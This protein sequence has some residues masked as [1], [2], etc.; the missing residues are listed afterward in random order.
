[1]NK[2]TISLVKCARCAHEWWPR[3]PEPPKRCAHCKALNWQRP[4]HVKREPVV[5]TRPPGAV[6]KYPFHDLEVGAS[7]LIEL[8]RLPESG[9]PDRKKNQSIHCA[10]MNY[11][12]RSGRQ[13]QRETTVSGI[14]VTRTM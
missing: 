7:V 8:H 4:A 13:Y 2:T 11:A 12:R 10:V 1:M 5:S 3:T 9:M 14:R 6:R